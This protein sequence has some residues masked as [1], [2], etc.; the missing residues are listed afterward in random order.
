LRKYTGQKQQSFLRA[1]SIDVG[2][3]RR[4][5][6]L[7]KRKTRR[8]SA[9][10]HAAT[11]KLRRGPLRLSDIHHPVYLPLTSWPPSRYASDLVV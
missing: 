10:D 5:T 9:R 1:S 11:L 6:V 7:G 4:T 8:N 2:S 3:L